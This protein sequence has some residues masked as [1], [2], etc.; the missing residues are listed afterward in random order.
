MEAVSELAG[1][2]G[3]FSSCEAISVPRSSFYRHRRQKIV[4]VPQSRPRSHRALSEDE[5][6]KVL[7]VLHCR[8]YVDKAPR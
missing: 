6:K 7:E 8:K 1:T 5:H 3:I 4:K 2:I